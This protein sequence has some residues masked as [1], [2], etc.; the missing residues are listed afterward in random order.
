VANWREHSVYMGGY[1]D[2]SVQVLW[3]WQVRGVPL[4]QIA[5]M[6]TE[7]MRVRRVTRDRTVDGNV[8]VNG[9][10]CG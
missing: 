9:T 3:F 5:G 6:W 4:L 8:E 7:M 10:T 1:R 2:S